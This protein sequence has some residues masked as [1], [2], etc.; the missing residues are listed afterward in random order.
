MTMKLAFLGCGYVANM[1]RLTGARAYPDL[2]A[3][4]ADPAIELG[5]S[6]G[7]AHRSSRTRH[8]ARTVA[9]DLLAAV[10]PGRNRDRSKFAKIRPHGP[11][12]R[13]HHFGNIFIN[14]S[15]RIGAN[16]TLRQGVTIG[17]RIE[18]GPVPTIGDN[19]DFGAYAQA[20][21]GVHIGNN[22]RIGAMSVV[23]CDV[24][25]GCTAVGNPVRI[26][27]SDNGLS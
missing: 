27:H 16:C 7:A 26:I 18:D 1:Y 19:V 12:F 24:P 21:G 10:A 3:I 22:C 8:G 6:L 2:D 11:G 15:V 25:D 5:I 17:N 4:L 14:P 9:Q 20:L 13:I 23:L